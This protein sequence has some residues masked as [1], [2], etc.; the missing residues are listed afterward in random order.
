MLDSSS[1]KLGLGTVQ[2]GLPYGISNSKGLIDVRTVHEILDYGLD[3]VETLDTAAAYGESEKRIGS[4]LKRLNSE[5]RKHSYRLVT[6][7]PPIDGDNISDSVLKE[8]RNIFESSLSNLSV[9]QLHGLLIHNSD[10]LLKPGCEKL[11]ELMLSFKDRKLVKKVG[12]S[13]YS[14]EQLAKI[15]EKHPI[16]LVQVPLSIF[17]QRFIESNTLQSLK[18]GGVE[19]HVRSIF[20]QGLIFLDPSQLRGSLTK[21]K[22]FLTS[23]RDELARLNMTPLE[24]VFQFLIEKSGFIDC[25]I[26]GSCAKQELFETYHCLKSVES[27]PNQ[28][29]NPDKWSSNDESLINPSKWK[30]N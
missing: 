5:G 25:V 18:Q 24:A 16:D 22:K 17:D 12:V 21:H 10:D 23:F 4:Y 1:L 15:L 6:K 20:T 26:I 8:A 7:L 2:F 14:P 30:L 3:F 13:V 28:D 9:N 27:S 29:F 19:V 11:Y